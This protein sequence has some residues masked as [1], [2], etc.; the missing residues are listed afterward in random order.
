MSR[1]DLAPRVKDLIVRRLKLDIDPTTIDDAAPLFGEG[2]GLDSIDALE[3]V[4]GL[5]QEFQHQGR[6]R[7]GRRQ[8]LRLR[9]RPLRLHRA[10]EDAP[11]ADRGASARLPLPL[12]GRGVGGARR[13][14]LARAACALGSRPTAAAAM[15]EAWQSPLLFAEA[16]A[17]AALLLEGA[18][19][20]AA[21]RGF[22]A[23]IEG[24]AVGA[25]AA[26]RARRSRSRVRLAARFGAV[27]RF[28]GEVL[29]GGEVLARGSVLVR[30]GGGRPTKGAEGRP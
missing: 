19:P 4:L 15:G 10:E 13:R 11:D 9:R 17:Q 25:P 20:S 6:G 8:G 7:G 27:V 23:G 30:K 1:Q 18:I 3:L 26:R 29:S 12:R 21:A 5:E 24:F 28:D 22:L 14:L 2:L 16:I